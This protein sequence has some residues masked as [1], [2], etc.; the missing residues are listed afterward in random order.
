M[1]TMLLVILQ[2]TSLTGKSG[3]THSQHQKDSQRNTVMFVSKMNAFLLWWQPKRFPYLFKVTTKVVW[4][5]Q[6]FV[7][8]TCFIHQCP[9]SVLYFWYWIGLDKSC[10]WFLRQTAFLINLRYIRTSVYA[11]SW[12]RFLRSNDAINILFKSMWSK[13]LLVTNFLQTQNSLLTHTYFFVAILTAYNL[14]GN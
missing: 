7:T 10:S 1:I 14:P 8:V 11:V 6:W 2:F 13:M 4:H 3:E 5:S 12:H 9:F